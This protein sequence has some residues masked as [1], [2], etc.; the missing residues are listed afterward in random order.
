VPNDNN[1][2]EDAFVFDRRTATT[3]RISIDT[4]GVEGNDA[5]FPFALSADGQV[6]VMSSF[7]SNLVVGDANG[8]L[9][10]FVRDRTRGVTERVSV[11][12]AGAEGNRYSAGGL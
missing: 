4:N 6:V 1:F 11:D 2:V 7:A 9:D 3:E 8:V 10:V 5:S 12:S